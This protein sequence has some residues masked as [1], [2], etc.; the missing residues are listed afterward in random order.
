MAPFDP[1]GAYQVPQVPVPAPAPLP[2]PS[3]YTP[4]VVVYAACHLLSNSLLSP[5]L[6]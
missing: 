2:A 1:Y 4:Q 3:G 5:C 6:S